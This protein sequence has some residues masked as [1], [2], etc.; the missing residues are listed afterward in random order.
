[1]SWWDNHDSLPTRAS[2][3][4][5]LKDWDDQESWQEFFNTYW[6]LIFGAARRAGLSDAEAEDVV[7]EVVFTLC[8]KMKDFKYDPALG[9]FKGY[10]LRTTQWRV[11]DQFKKRRPQEQVLQRRPDDTGSTDPLERMP[12]PAN[13]LDD[14][15]DEEWR[16][17]LIDAALERV[18]WQVSAKHFQIY[19]AYVVKD[20]PVSQVMETLGV[21]RTEVYL[22]KHRV[23]KVVQ[24]T[25]RALEEDLV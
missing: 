23:G 24:Q 19:D 18:Q 22:A 20:W 14:V 5:R 25:I 15:W 1:M 9:K 16:K 6:K 12:D 7:Q 11:N 8:K 2:L 21:S 3:L 13:N 4:S 17:N 10:L